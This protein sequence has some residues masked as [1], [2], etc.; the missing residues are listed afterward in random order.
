MLGP[1][2]SMPIPDLI[3]SPLNLVKKAGEDNKFRL[4]HNLAYPYNENA[5]NTN[6]P[7]HKAKVIYQQ[8]DLVIKLGLK[9][10]RSAHASK[11]DFDAAFRNFPIILSNL[12]VLGFTLEEQFFINSSMAFGARS[13]CKIFEEFA[14]AIQWIMEKRTKS[15]DLSHYLD[16]FIMVH[17]I[18]STCQWYMSE[19]I[20]LCHRIGVPLSGKKAEGPTQVITFLGLLIDFLNQIITIPREKVEKAMNLVNL[21]LNSLTNTDKNKKGK[22]T[23]EILQ[24]LT[25]LLNF[26]CRAIPSGRPF[27]RRLYSLQAKAIPA[28][29]RHHSNR[30]ACP[31]Y[32]GR[33]DRGARKDLIMWKNF[34]TNPRFSQHRQV[35]FLHFL[36]TKMG[37]LIF[38]DASRSEQFGFGCVFPSIGEWTNTRWPIAMFHDHRYKADIA[39]F[40]L[41]A[42]VIAIETWAPA[43]AGKQVQLRSDNEATVFMLNAKTSKKECHMNLLRHLTLTCMSFQIYVTARH[44]SGKSNIMADAL[45]WLQL[46][47]FFS[48]AP[49]NMNRMR[50]PLPASLWPISWQRLHNL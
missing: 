43:L 48:V 28:A 35:P 8:F 30:K 1:Y 15:K 22:V 19:M 50:T 31:F 6:I 42:I 32:K 16:D 10:G 33:L 26:L 5:V 25:G 3:C 37:P 24:S 44:E 41:Y 4:I 29:S 20:E 40:E 21:A 2:P 45:L 7:D 11:L 46:Q 13:S 36:G 47:R 39:L 49:S 12:E 18:K 34:L 14:C 27:L 17:A 38:A 9:H 23:V